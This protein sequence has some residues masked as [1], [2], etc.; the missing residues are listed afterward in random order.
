MASVAYRV[1]EGAFD[2]VEAF[3]ASASGAYVNNMIESSPV[4]VNIL[5]DRESNGDVV[6]KWMFAND[7]DKDTFVDFARSGETDPA[8]VGLGQASFP[9][10][11][12]AI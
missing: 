12:Y 11:T 7:A 4:D 10:R 9:G 1:F 5:M 3:Q 2:S 8:V 6:V